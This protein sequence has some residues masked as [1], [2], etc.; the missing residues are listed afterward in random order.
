MGRQVGGRP[1]GWTDG[2]GMPRRRDRQGA[3]L[4][5]RRADCKR[6]GGSDGPTADRSRWD[7]GALHWLVICTVVTDDSTP[8]GRGYGPFPEESEPTMPIIRPDADDRTG[9]VVATTG[10]V[11]TTGQAAV[12]GPV[13]T[14]HQAASAG[15]METTRQATLAAPVE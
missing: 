10:P 12:A 7:I 11:E 6:V 8:A 15:P 4:A 13:E 14:T 3:R 5:S 1:G 2:S 9:G